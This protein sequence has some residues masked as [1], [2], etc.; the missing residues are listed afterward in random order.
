MR[1]QELQ[2]PNRESHD[3]NMHQQNFVGKSQSTNQN[4]DQFG[5][6]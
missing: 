3:S 4:P 6:L 2:A 1:K 5:N